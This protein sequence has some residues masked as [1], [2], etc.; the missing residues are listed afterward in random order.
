M[1]MVYPSNDAIITALRK[2]GELP[3]LA[4][5]VYYQGN[6][7]FI[8]IIRPGDGDPRKLGS[9][10][11]TSV[12]TFQELKDAAN[13]LPWSGSPILVQVARDVADQHA[14]AWVAVNDNFEPLMHGGQPIFAEYARTVC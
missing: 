4:V 14:C 3:Q 11:A 2:L 7:F 5:I 12:D 9:Y 10:G 8:E 1:A 13:R 6:R